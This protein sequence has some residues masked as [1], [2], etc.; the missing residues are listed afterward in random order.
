MG[1]SGCENTGSETSGM[2]EH[3]GRRVENTGMSKD[4]GSRSSGL[5]KKKKKKKEKKDRVGPVGCLTTRG[6][7]SWMSEHREVS[8][9]KLNTE[10][11]TEGCQ[12]T[13]GHG[14]VGCQRT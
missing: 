2:F 13:Q 5:S 11:G 1:P 10:T 4:T 12:R 6:N 9:V 7:T 14:A 8:V 3:I